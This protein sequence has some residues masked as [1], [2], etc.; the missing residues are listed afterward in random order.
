MIPKNLSDV[1]L[2]LRTDEER[3]R[4][5]RKVSPPKEVGKNYYV[6]KY[7]KKRRPR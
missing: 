3:E 4:D 2:D 6:H 1:M 7:A 5:K